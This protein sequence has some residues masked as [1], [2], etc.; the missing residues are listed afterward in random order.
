[1]DE[2]LPPNAIQKLE[3]ME[4]R[5]SEL[6]GR[7]ADPSF[8]SNP[9]ATRQFMR[10]IGGLRKLVEPY[11]EYRSTREQVTEALSLLDGKDDPELRSLAEEELP[12]LRRRSTELAGKLLDSL[13]AD[14]ADT[15]R[16][17]IVEIRAGTGGEEAALFA[18]DLF[19]MYS[20]FAE[21]Q[22][23]KTE[24][25][26]VSESDHG[27]YREV[28]FTIS[29]DDIFTRMRFESGG[30]RVQRVPATEAQGRIHTS[31]AT[32]AVLPEVEEL[33]LVIQD[34]D[35][36]IDAMR[37]SGPGGQHVN[38]TSSAIRITHLPTNTVVVCQEERSQHKNRSRAMSILRSRLFEAERQRRDRER[39]AARKAQVGSG[40]RNERVR[41]YNFPQNRVTDHRINENFSLDLVIEGR[42]GPILEK[43][44][45]DERERR[46]KEI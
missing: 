13:L 17:A 30:H 3:E 11:R 36:K 14:P 41:T 8:A 43:L 6:L 26:S 10:E 24:T 38:K 31:A 12:L 34:K 5:L 45:A 37:A 29:G 15:D 32:V 40:D 35:L 7:A 19:R 20:R 23:W 25:L 33:E 46:L 21:S 28:I 44:L 39:A 27:G 1:M 18:R 42:L 2:T 9:A 16:N 22:G 4:A